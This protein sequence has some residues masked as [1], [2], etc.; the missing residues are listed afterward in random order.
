MEQEI[1]GLQKKVGKL[2]AEVKKQEMENKRMGKE[3]EI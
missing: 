2:E 3:K 1:E